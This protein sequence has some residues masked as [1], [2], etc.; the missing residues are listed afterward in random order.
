MMYHTIQKFSDADYKIAKSV[1]IPLLDIREC[2][3]DLME[4]Y[5]KS[6]DDVEDVIVRIGIE[7]KNV[8]LFEF[9]EAARVG[10]G[11]SYQIIHFIINFK[12][13]DFIRSEVGEWPDEYTHISYIRLPEK[14]TGKIHLKS[15][16]PSRAI[17][18]NEKF[19]KLPADQQEVLK[20]LI[21]KETE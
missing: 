3:L 18:K 6:F 20:K 13:G 5:E 4:A 19:Q 17:D 14:P 8:D 10:S 7:W 12:N 1:G 16:I 21:G 9:L 15:L 11:M 2:I